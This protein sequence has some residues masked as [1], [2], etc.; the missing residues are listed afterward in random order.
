MGRQSKYPI[1]L[2]DE[3]RNFLRSLI[4]KGSSPARVQTH[5]RILLLAEKE[6]GNKKIADALQSDT[7]TVW[8]TRKRFLAGGL[9]TALYHKPPKNKKSRIL[10]GRAEAHLIALACGEPPEGRAKWSVRLLASRMVELNYVEEIS[11]ETVR[12]T[13][14]KMNSRHT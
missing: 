10:D 12:K 11:R 3:Q 7:V 13:L 2:N 1:Q 8:R 14:K 9:D 6:Q 5:A 4:R